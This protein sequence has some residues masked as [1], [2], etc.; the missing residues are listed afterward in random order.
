MQETNLYTVTIPPIRKS[1]QALSGLLDKLDTHASAKQLDWHP[2]KMQESALLNSHLIADQFPLIKQIQ[3]ACDNAKGGAARLAE[4]EI[5]KFED[6]EKT[7][8]ELKAR[9]AKTIAFIDTIK[10]EQIIGKEGVTVSLP[11]WD[12]KTL[13]GFEYVTEYLLPN[14]YF[15]VTTAYSI[16]RTNGVAIGKSD[17]LGPLPLK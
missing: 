9:I 15:H 10:P 3:V 13:T 11:F 5:P 12:G 14:F 7:V 16:L 2:P 8:E 6:T 17:Y 1:L 4:V